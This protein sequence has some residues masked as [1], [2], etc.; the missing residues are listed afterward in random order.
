MEAP[1]KRTKG[2]REGVGEAEVSSPISESVGGTAET[3]K[4]P[5]Q[6]DKSVRNID[7][8]LRMR[9]LET[10]NSCAAETKQHGI[11]DAFKNHGTRI[12]EEPR[13]PS[14]NILMNMRD[15]RWNWLGYILRTN[16][17]KLSSSELRHA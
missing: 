12:A 16:E 10:Y 5:T 8:T 4:P 17:D 1:R 13:T 15:S 3:E 7:V 2:G 14:A 11:Q 6:I 9:I